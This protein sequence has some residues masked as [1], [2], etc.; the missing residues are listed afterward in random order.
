MI[1]RCPPS[2]NFPTTCV[3][4]ACRG[5]P[6]KTTRSTTTGWSPW[7]VTKI[8]SARQNL[9]TFSGWGSERRDLPAGGVLRQTPLTVHSLSWAWQ[10]DQLAHDH[11]NDHLHFSYCNATHMN[12]QNQAGSVAKQ[13]K[14]SIP[15]L[16]QNTLL[17]AGKQK[18]FTLT[19]SGR[20]SRLL[21]RIWILLWR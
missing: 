4:C 5:W 11:D 1:I 13:S 15:H 14:K 17:C 20:P 7:S 6:V 12:A 19:R 3:Q 16:F 8:A 21:G 2:G 9:S 10:D 18:L